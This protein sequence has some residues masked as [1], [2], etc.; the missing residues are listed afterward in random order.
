M[1][2]RAGVGGLLTGENAERKQKMNETGCEVT[3]YE[4]Q[5]T[6][7]TTDENYPTTAVLLAQH[8]CYWSCK[9]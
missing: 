2:F 4:T 3:G 9:Q 1:G 6:E 8:A 5:R 7:K